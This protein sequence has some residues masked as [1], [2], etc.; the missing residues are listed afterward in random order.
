MDSEKDMVAQGDSRTRAVG[1]RNAGPKKMATRMKRK[2]R[3]GC[4][5]AAK[6]P[7]RD[8]DGDG[9]IESMVHV[10]QLRRQRFRANL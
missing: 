9:V 10:V 2:R 7:M 8:E 6:R 4:E 5:A 1:C 3:G